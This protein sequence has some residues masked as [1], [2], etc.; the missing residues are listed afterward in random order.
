MSDD[1]V[2]DIFRMHEYYE[3]HTKVDEL[4]A[5]K[6][7]AYLKFRIDF[8]QEEIEEMREAFSLDQPEKVVDALIDLCVV[9]IGTLDVF[10]IDLYMAW[11]EVLRA[12]MNKRVGIK[13]ER[14]NPFGLPDLVKPEGWREPSHRGN[15]GDLD[16]ALSKPAYGPCEI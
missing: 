14:P 6:L 13:P 2:D 3:F 11:D 4:S 5:D 8:L 12:N 9:A 10:N 16:K 15:T 7:K 1:W